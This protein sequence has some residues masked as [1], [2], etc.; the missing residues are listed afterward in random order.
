MEK[1]FKDFVIEVITEA[2]DPDA[3]VKKQIQGM[4]DSIGGA[5]EKSLK[6]HSQNELRDIMKI[7]AN[8]FIN[9][10]GESWPDFISALVSA[11]AKKKQFIDEKDPNKGIWC[12]KFQFMYGFFEF[13]FTQVFKF[14]KGYWARGIQKCVK[15]FEE[16]QE[17]DKDTYSLK[18][19]NEVINVFKSGKKHKKLFVGVFNSL[20][21]GY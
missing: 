17:M 9:L 2:G 7:Y 21:R 5:L 4:A 15:K 20:M 14:K 8:C 18:T 10:R 11:C 16:T 1:T 13:Y 12:T 19:A 3:T 6:N